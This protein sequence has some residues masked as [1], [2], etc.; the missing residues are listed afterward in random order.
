MFL[1]FFSSLSLFLQG[2][3]ILTIRDYLPIAGSRSTLFAATDP[4][5]SEYC[6]LLKADNWPVCAFLSQECRPTNP[7]EEAHNGETSYQLWE[8]TMEMVGLSSDVVER[9]LEGEQVSC[10]YGADLAE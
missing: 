1:C 9:L 10:R 8:K 3:K 5:I 7:S 2:F 6:E 4:Q